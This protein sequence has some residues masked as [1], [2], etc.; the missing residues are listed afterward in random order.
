MTSS[1]WSW[2]SLISSTSISCEP[3]KVSSFRSICL[4]S[5]SSSSSFKGSRYAFTNGALAGSLAAKDQSAGILNR[6]SAW[7]LAYLIKGVAL[8]IALLALHSPPSSSSVVV[9]LVRILVFKSDASVATSH[10]QFTLDSILVKLLHRLVV[11][12]ELLPTHEHVNTTKVRRTPYTDLC[13]SNTASSA[14]VF[15]SMA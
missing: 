10:S 1:C 14:S 13:F 9:F 3:T 11:L 5:S 2:S 7:G 15:S 4:K 12:L 6:T 8:D